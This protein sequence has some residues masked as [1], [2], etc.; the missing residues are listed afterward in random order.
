MKPYP[1]FLV[2]LAARECV[3]VGGDAEAE[4]KVEG[5]LECDA[6]VRVVAADLAPGLRRLAAAGRLTWE[7][8]P[9]RR[10]DLARA[11]LVIVTDRGDPER[12]RQAWEEAAERGIPINTVDDVE[13]CSFIAGSVVRRGALTVAVSTAGA[14]PALAVRLRER[15]ERELGPELGEF[16]DLAAE[17]REELAR[18]VPVFG[19]RR[20]AWYRLVD[21]DVLDLLRAGR[22]EQARARALELLGLGCTPV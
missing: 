22:R 16:L 19:A 14:A 2:G 11:A 3:V 15:L 10:G 13:H 18:R 5:L 8:R 6:A 21:S 7:P 17:L 20:E 9:Y 1:I 4:R 12:V